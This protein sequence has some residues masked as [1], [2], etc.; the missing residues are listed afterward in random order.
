MD[1]ECISQHMCML[2][3][4]SLTHTHTHYTHMHMTIEP[5]KNIDNDFMIFLPIRIVYTIGQF[6][7]AHA[8][9]TYGTCGTCITNWYVLK[10]KMRFDWF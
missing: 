10:S 4:L 7:A 3:N 1:G 8:I 5:P 2:E 6:S 9:A